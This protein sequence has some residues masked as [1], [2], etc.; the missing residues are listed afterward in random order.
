MSLQIRRPAVAV[1][2]CA[3]LLE[4][5]AW[6]WSDHA[7]LT[8][9]ILGNELDDRTVTYQE[10]GE[11]V[12]G[13]DL[14]KPD[15][16]KTEAEKAAGGRVPLLTEEEL[17]CYLRNQKEP[18]LPIDPDDEDRLEHKKGFHFV[19]K[20]GEAPD[21]EVAL[22]DV[23]A[24]YADEP[25]WDMDTYIFDE[26]Q[27]RELEY[28]PAYAMMG[29]PDKMS[30]QSFRH[31]LWPK[32]NP[33]HPINSLK[34][35]VG[36]VLKKMGVTDDRAAEYV[37]L[38]RRA[39]AAGSEYWQARFLANALHY[40]QD[41][42]QPFHAAQ[43][44]SKEYMAMATPLKWA[45]ELLFKLGDLIKIPLRKWDH[46]ECRENGLK[47]LTRCV[48]QIVSYYHFSYE[49][50]IQ[51]VM[52]GNA[53]LPAVRNRLVDA[54]QSGRHA[55]GMSNYL[56]RDAARMT[57]SVSE[58]AGATS[59]DAGRTARDF[60]PRIPDADGSDKPDYAA[61]DPYPYFESDTPE[62]QAWLAEVNV[63]AQTP[64]AARDEYFAT[65]DKAFGD[66][67]YAVRQVVRAE[68]LP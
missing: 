52:N 54:L 14:A 47:S 25:D 67:G 31:M 48:T 59:D 10:L 57:L 29:D 7:R 8:R 30:S 42:N 18:T 45:P 43:I 68:L 65:V 40:I 19:E 39:K 26:D 49:T 20:A 55:K 41:A 58:A 32:W 3:F 62:G 44:P 21:Q 24:V 64:S 61:F 60:F 53:E 66:L 36:K 2:G 38:A 33:K 50:F 51:E 46:P 16:C 17:H 11:V 34:L 63:L 22:I 15:W 4:A 23:L 28:D 13:L 12:P 5:S 56:D 37:D 35:P 1:L 27:Y 6:A 9:V